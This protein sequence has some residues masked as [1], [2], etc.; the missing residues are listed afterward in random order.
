MGKPEIAAKYY[1][2][3]IG[4]TVEL[5]QLMDVLEKRADIDCDLLRVM[6]VCK[7]RIA[8]AAEH[9]LP[10]VPQLIEHHEAVT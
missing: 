10:G 8:L 7:Q 4:L 5:T 9:K 6:E 2:K 1:D 3:A